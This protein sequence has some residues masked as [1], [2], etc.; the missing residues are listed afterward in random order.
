MA[1]SPEQ[2]WSSK[3]HDY[4]APFKITLPTFTSANTEMEIPLPLPAVAAHWGVA[5]LIT[6]IDLTDL[7]LILQLLL[8]ERSVLVIGDSSDLVTSC[9]CAI[10]ELLKPYEWASNFMPLLPSDMI[11]FVSSPVPFLIGMV[12]DNYHQTR[13]IEND[14]RVLEAMQD[15]LSVINLS[16]RSVSLTTEDNIVEILTGCPTPK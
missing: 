3:N 7:L 11:D 12:A 8:V 10:M 9:A 2:S 1:L 5:T 6:R 16:T 14:E 4:P 13:L 15:G